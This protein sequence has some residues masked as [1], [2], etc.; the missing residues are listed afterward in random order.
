MLQNAEILKSPLTQDSNVKQHLAK[1]NVHRPFSLEKSFF[2]ANLSSPTPK[3]ARK[4]AF[5]VMTKVKR[6]IGDIFTPYSVTSIGDTAN[7]N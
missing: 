3:N 5:D 1:R 4:L 6:S 7:S 2:L